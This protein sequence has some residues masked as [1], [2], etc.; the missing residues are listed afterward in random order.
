[1]RRATTLPLIPS[2]TSLDVLLFEDVY[3]KDL[4]A[5]IREHRDPLTLGQQ[6]SPAE[7]VLHRYRYSELA[8]RALR[9]LAVRQAASAD[10]VRTIEARPE[11]QAIGEQMRRQGVVCRAAINKLRDRVR[12]QAPMSLATSEHFDDCLYRLIAGTEETLNWELAEGIPPI[13]NASAGS[14]SFPKFKSAM[15]VRQHAPTKLNPS[16][17]RWYERTPV[18]SRLLTFWDLLLEIQI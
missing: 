15:Y 13:R 16:G 8:K 1:M 3:L 5:Q 17:P 2:N 18:V 9:H 6:I 12:R 10:V 4:F 11:F 7:S 14:E